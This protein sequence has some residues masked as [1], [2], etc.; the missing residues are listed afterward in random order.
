MFVYVSEGRGTTCIDDELATRPVFCSYRGFPNTPKSETAVVVVV[1]PFLSN[2][3]RVAHPRAAVKGARG[4]GGG[5]EMASVIWRQQTF[6]RHD[7]SQADVYL[8]YFPAR[9]PPL[10]ATSTNNK[11]P[12]GEHGQPTFRN[13]HIQRHLIKEASGNKEVRSSVEWIT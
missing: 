3:R 7:V 11:T 10:E 6:F 2:P 13:E 1:I 9:F 8:Y 12:R 5:A 4:R